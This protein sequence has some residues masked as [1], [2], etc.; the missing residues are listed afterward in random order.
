M[1]HVSGYHTLLGG[2]EKENHNL[3]YLINF[4]LAAKVQISK[5]NAKGKLLFLLHFRVKVPFE[6]KLKGVQS[7]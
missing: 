7:I 6:S 5:R 4:N 1:V 3:L 2:L